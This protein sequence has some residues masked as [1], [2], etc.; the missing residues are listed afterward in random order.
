MIGDSCHVMVDC[1]TFNKESNDSGIIEVAKFDVQVCDN[2]SLS[3]ISVA[4]F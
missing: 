1:S 4:L 2:P 3:D